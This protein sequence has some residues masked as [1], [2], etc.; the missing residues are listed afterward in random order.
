MSWCHGTT[1]G[2]VVKGRG[3]KKKKKPNSEGF[4]FYL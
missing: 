3:E 4:R 2:E 1:D